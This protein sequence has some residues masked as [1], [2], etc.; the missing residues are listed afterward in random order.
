ME[1]K[2]KQSNEKKARMFN[3]IGELIIDGYTSKEIAK[4]IKLSESSVNSY[5]NTMLALYNCTNRIQLAVKI[6]TSK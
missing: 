5:I 2:Q 3:R 1:T 6:A 4:K